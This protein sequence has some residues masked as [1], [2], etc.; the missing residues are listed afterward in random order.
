MAEEKSELQKTL[1][2][3]AEKL[4]M[5]LGELRERDRKLFSESVHEHADCLL[6]DEFNNEEFVAT[7][8]HILSCTYCASLIDVHHEMHE[9]KKNPLKLDFKPSV[10]WVL[11]LREALEKVGLPT[12]PSADR[13]EKAREKKGAEVVNHIKLRANVAR[14]NRWPS[15]VLIENGQFTDFRSTLNGALM[16]PDTPLGEKAHK[17]LASEFREWVI[18]NRTND[19]LELD[20]GHHI[21]NRLHVVGDNVIGYVNRAKLPPFEGPNCS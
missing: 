10:D 12:Q 19:A 3:R 7:V 11:A 2:S 18:A 16:I 20:V 4:G 6:P 5:S 15:F 9:D 8:A 13:I 17:L 21:L 1:E 14:V